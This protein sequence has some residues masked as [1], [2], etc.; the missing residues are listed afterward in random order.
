MAKRFS[1]PAIA[2]RDFLGFHGKICRLAICATVIVLTIFQVIFGYI[3]ISHYS[4]LIKFEQTCAIKAELLMAPDSETDHYNC[5][6]DKSSQNITPRFD[7]KGLLQCLRYKMIFLGCRSQHNHTTQTVR[8]LKDLALAKTLRLL[9]DN[10]IS[11]MLLSMLATSQLTFSIWSFIIF[12]KAFYGVV[13]PAIISAIIAYRRRRKIRHDWVKMYIFFVIM[14]F[15]ILFTT[16]IY[17]RTFGIQIDNGIHNLFILLSYVLLGNFIDL[18][19][20]YPVLF[21]VFIYNDII[22]DKILYHGPAWYYGIGG[23]GFNDGDFMEPLAGVL[24]ASLGLVIRA[25]L[26]YAW[27]RWY[28]WRKIKN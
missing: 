20:L 28:I 15:L 1:L 22:W 3:Y 7:A 21:T 9:G 12:E 11:R 18:W 2:W 19:L 17:H 8:I 4:P 10:N 13:I 6:F 23:L 26:A 16:T 14:S 24:V 27:K 25:L 5:K